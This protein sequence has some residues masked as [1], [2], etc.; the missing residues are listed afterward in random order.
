MAVRVLAV[1]KVAVFFLGG[2]A[3]FHEQAGHVQHR[4]RR[5]ESCLC[6]AIPN[7]H[8]FG[9]SR[10]DDSI[11]ESTYDY[12]QILNSQTKLVLLTDLEAWACLL[13]VLMS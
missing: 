1:L 10:D 6:T 3:T 7:V 9:V 8:Q 13:D 5:S 2:S 4:C 11:E 12:V